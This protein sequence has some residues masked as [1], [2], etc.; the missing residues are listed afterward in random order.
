ML[1]ITLILSLAQ[2][3]SAGGAAES[4]H[5]ITTTRNDDGFGEALDGGQDLNGDG[6]PEILVGQPDANAIRVFSGIDGALLYVKRGVTT[7]DDHGASVAFT[8]DVDGDG[9][10]DFIAGAPLYSEF[11][12]TVGAAYVYSGA[13]GQKIHTF[14]GPT[15]PQASFFGLAVA[16]VGDVNA[17]GHEDLIVGARSLDDGR[18]AIFVYSGANSALLYRVNG[19]RP[20]T[21]L[22]SSVT[23]VGDLNLDGVPDFVAGA[24]DY[25]NGHGAVFAYSGVDGSLLY[26]AYGSRESHNFGESIDAAGDVNQDGFP[27]ILIGAPQFGSAPWHGSVFLISGKD[28]SKIY[29]WRKPF[30]HSF[31]KSVAGVGDMNDDGIPDIA[32]GSP[33]VNY[34]ADIQA[35]SA[36]LFS[37]AD[38][39][40]LHRWIGTYASRLGTQ[41]A[42]AGDLDGDGRNDVLMS[43]VNSGTGTV[44][45]D[46][47]STFLSTDSYQVSNSV[48]GAI[49]L[50]LDFPTT[51]GN[52]TYQILMSARG[53][54][55]LTYGVPIPLA[56]DQILQQSVHGVYPFA[57]SFGMTGLLDASGNS[58]ATISVAPDSVPHLMGQTY[59]ISAIIRV[60]GQTATLCSSAASLTIIP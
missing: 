36:F 46:K 16:G 49:Q 50:D 32:I 33:H 13:T 48:G 44:H 21:Y 40:L 3:E 53:I 15:N 6:Y 19:Q 38:G 5:V 30:S 31:G 37:G 20:Y 23:G 22:G 11:F 12:S 43:A 52:H 60:P 18:G 17:D 4:L 34:G 35:G 42:Q 29:R 59:W 58:T 57:T 27:D 47:F 2:F 55:P 8:G 45:A 25:W 39:H 54:G 28:G 9:V 14:I 41:V 7:Q 24:E 26:E 1:L 56:K 51:V 10:S